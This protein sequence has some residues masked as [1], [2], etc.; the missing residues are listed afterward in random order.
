MKLLGWNL[1][2]D[3]LVSCRNIA[4]HKQGQ[5]H[6]WRYIFVGNTRTISQSALQTFQEEMGKVLN[7]PY[8][9]LDGL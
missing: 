3:G 7:D 5:G 9:V 8:K 4:I 6:E 2:R 1:T